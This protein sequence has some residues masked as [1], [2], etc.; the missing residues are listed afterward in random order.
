MTIEIRSFVSSTGKGERSY[1][2]RTAPEEHRATEDVGQKWKDLNGPAP[3]LF[4]P[5]S[6]RDARDNLK[7]ASTKSTD[8]NLASFFWHVGRALKFTT[9]KKLY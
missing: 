8:E 2:E 6:L 4:Q 3:L 9:K 1:L 5:S 7:D